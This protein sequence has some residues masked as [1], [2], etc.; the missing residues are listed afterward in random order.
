MTDDALERTREFF[1]PRA[2]SWDERFPDDEAAFARAAAELGVPS[3]ASVLDVGCGTGRALPALRAEV[4]V[5]GAVIGLD[6]TPEMLATARS[7]GRDGDGALVLADSRSVPLVGASVDAVFAA[8]LITHVSD[9]EGT[10]RELARVTRPTGR[11]ALFH[12]IGRTALAERHGRALRPGEL[13]DPKV[14]PGVLAAAGWIHPEIDDARDRY[15][16]LAVRR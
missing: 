6:V 15:W 1:G 2:A 16:A 14:L 4:G 10:L 11:L 8:G 5:S 3:G 9:P 13:L 12:P 7:K